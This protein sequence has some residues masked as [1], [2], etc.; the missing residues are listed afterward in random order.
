MYRNDIQKEIIDNNLQNF[1]NYLEVL[2]A[3]FEENLKPFEKRMLLEF[4]QLKAIHEDIKAL[5]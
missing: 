5:E 3:K 4:D 1:S 2:E